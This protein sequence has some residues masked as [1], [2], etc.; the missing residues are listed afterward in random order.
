[1]VGPA[2]ALKGAVGVLLLLAPAVAAAQNFA[3]EAGCRD[4]QPH[5]AY[6][7]RSPS[8]QL[9]VVGAYNRGKRA[10][11]FLFWSSAGARVAQLPYDEDVRSGTLAAWYVAA[12]GVAEPKR[13]LEATYVRGK[14]AG[15]HRTWYPNGA[16]RGQFRYE[17]GTLVDARAFAESG[18]PL[19]EAEARALAARDLEADEKFVATLE[20]L[21]RSNL[22]RCDSGADRLEKG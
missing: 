6:E 13:R 7:L 14:L 16:V 2:Q 9:R 5:G 3:I 11:S 20:A 17:L 22:P 18:K 10:G 4:G 12:D 15:T 21:V 1:M 8:G 19:P